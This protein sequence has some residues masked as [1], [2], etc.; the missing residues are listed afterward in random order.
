MTLIH[1][2]I[3]KNKYR[4]NLLVAMLTLLLS[5]PLMFNSCNQIKV[6]LVS[7]IKISN[8]RLFFDGD[9]QMVGVNAVDRMDG[10]YD[11]AFMNIPTGTQDPVTNILLENPIIP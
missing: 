3:M 4:L 6:S 9:Q 8:S 2:K 7:E 1:P 11:Y 5:F 10:K